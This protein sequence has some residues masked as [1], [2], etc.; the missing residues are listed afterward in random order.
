MLLR[1][2]SATLHTNLVLIYHVCLSGNEHL[3]HAVVRMLINLPQPCL[4]IVK[5]LQHRAIVGKYDAIGILVVALGDRAESLLP[6]SVPYL[7]LHVSV[8]NHS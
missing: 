1:Q 7:E 6:S 4:N 5:G 3:V 8:I 2:L